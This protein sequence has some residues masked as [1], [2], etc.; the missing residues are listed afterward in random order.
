MSDNWI[1]ERKDI[2]IPGFKRV[3]KL[4]PPTD[5]LSRVVW[6]RE[7]IANMDLINGESL[8][9]WVTNALIAGELQRIGC[10]EIVIHHYGG[11]GTQDADVTCITPDKGTMDR[12]CSSRQ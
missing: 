10:T 4:W 8:D 3:S 12:V 11:Q 6:I 7:D 2:E 5:E 9:H 1:T